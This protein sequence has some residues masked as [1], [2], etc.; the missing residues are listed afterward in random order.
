MSSE[1]F[2]WYI[3]SIAIV[4]GGLLGCSWLFYAMR[5]R[6]LD[7]WKKYYTALFYR[8]QE[9]ADIDIPL[10]EKQTECEIDQFLA[11]LQEQVRPIL[12]DRFVK[13]AGGLKRIIRMKH[14]LGRYL[15]LPLKV[16]GPVIALV[17]IL[18]IVM[19]ARLT[20]SWP[21]KAVLYFGVSAI[22]I[23]FILLLYVTIRDQINFSQQ[24]KV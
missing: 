3:L 20:S 11:Q 16:A 9:E 7:S 21:M 14:V 17:M 12:Y 5:S 2:F 4:L 6:L 15:F 10:A 1:N 24:A 13:V 19:R 18:L 8:L 23:Q 22:I